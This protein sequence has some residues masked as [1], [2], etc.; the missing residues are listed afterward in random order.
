LGAALLKH[1]AR[2]CLLL[3]PVALG[4]VTLVFLLL[5][6]VRGDPALAYLGPKAG[7]AAI[8]ALRH[9]W[10]LDQ[11]LLT[12][13]VD[14]LRSVVTLDFGESLKYHTP[15]KELLAPRL[16]MT[17]LLIAFAA[18][19][20]VAVAAPLGVV[21]ALREGKEGDWLVRLANAL[22][23]GMPQFWIGYVLI[24]V[25]A[26]VLGLFP[27]GGY[28]HTTAE[29]LH[30]LVLPSVA[31][32]LGIIPSLTKAVRSAMVEALDSEY[33]AYAT[34]KGLSRRAVVVDYALK[35]SA[36]TAISVLGINIGWLCGG[37]VVIEKVFGLTGLGAT[38]L[39]GILSRDFPVVQICTLV[40]ALIVMVVFLLTDLAYSLADPRVRLT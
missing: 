21:A 15:I 39:E 35:N 30:S 36:V 28:G 14:F 2:R 33:A 6:L 31:I 27:V 1:L 32:A 4:V 38:M 7:E 13:Y 34:S 24:I 8:Q 9:E 16:P 20:A 12:Q 26:L 40:Y 11:P 5:H 25:F 23:L 19:I 17:L 3:V 37:T 22:M 10:G 29:H 18:V